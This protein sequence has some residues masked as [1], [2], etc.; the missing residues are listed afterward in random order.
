MPL[1]RINITNLLNFY[2][3][4]DT[5]H[6]L[7]SKCVIMLRRDYFCI[8]MSKILKQSISEL[9]NMWCQHIIKKVS[10]EKTNLKLT[11]GANCERGWRLQDTSRIGAAQNF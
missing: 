11:D 10:R 6:K 3:R 9:D 7:K 1:V 2:F 5:F 4:S 8:S